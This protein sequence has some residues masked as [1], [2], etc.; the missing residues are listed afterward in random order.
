[1][2]MPMTEHLAVILQS[3]SFAG[4]NAY[5]YDREFSLLGM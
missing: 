2:P 3:F 1:M 4:G 5:A